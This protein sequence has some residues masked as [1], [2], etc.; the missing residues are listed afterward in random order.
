MD[1]QISFDGKDRS[2]TINEVCYLAQMGIVYPPLTSYMTILW[3]L[4]LAGF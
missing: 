1:I 3:N 4:M 2:P